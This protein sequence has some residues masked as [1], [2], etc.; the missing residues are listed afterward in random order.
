MK[1]HGYQLAGDTFEWPTKQDLEN[2]PLDKP[3]KISSMRQKQESFNDEKQRAL[4]F[5]EMYTLGR[6]ITQ[7]L[8]NMLKASKA[9]VPFENF[10]VKGITN[11]HS[12]LVPIRGA[13]S[14]SVFTKNLDEV[15]SSNLIDKFEAWGDEYVGLTKD[16]SLPAKVKV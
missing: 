5:G 4:L 10:D 13:Q 7:S 6:N 16:I 9:G 2:M 1:A 12:Q 8:G 15:K 3:A 14:H 11:L